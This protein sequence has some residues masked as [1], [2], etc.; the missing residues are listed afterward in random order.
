MSLILVEFI[1]NL[2]FF[3]IYLQY[4]DI[5]HIPR[6]KVY[7]VGVEILCSYTNNK[8]KYYHCI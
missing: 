6:F 8:I 3:P 1:I 2:L 4:I 7:R 5:L